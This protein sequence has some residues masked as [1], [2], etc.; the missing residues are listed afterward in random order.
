LT[1]SKLKLVDEE[2]RVMW[3]GDEESIR[4]DHSYMVP[5]QLEDFIGKH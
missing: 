4:D 2:G 3:F 5:E 1:P